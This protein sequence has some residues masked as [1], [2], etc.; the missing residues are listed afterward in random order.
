[1]LSSDAFVSS[2]FSLSGVP[3]TW[4]EARSLQSRGKGVWFSTHK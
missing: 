3:G 1:V 2:V 4:G